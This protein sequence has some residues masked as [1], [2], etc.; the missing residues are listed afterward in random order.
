MSMSLKIG[1]REEMTD[2]LKDQLQEVKAKTGLER[3]YV[4][5]SAELLVY[6]GQKTNTHSEKQLED[7]IRLQQERL[8]EESRVRMEM[9][10]FLKDVQRQ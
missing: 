3:K 10:T 8:E 5:S 6:Q 4:K 2:H 1:R 7:E 9:E